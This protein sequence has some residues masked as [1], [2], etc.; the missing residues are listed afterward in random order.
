MDRPSA[1][2]SEGLRIQRAVTN[3][4]GYLTVRMTLVFAG[5]GAPCAILAVKQSIERR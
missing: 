4:T 3:T 2:D 5:V 1:K